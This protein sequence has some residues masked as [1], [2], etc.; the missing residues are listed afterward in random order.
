MRFTLFGGE[1]EASISKNMQ[2]HLERAEWQQAAEQ[3]SKLIKQFQPDNLGLRLKLAEIY[4]KAGLRESALAQYQE[5]AEKYVEKDNPAKAI[6]IYLT[7]L[8]IDSGLPLVRVKLAELYVKRGE[9]EEAWKQGMEAIKCLEGRRLFPQVVTTLEIMSKL[10]FAD[11]RKSM[12]LAEMLQVRNQPEKAIGQFL[13]AAELFLQN[14]D[15]EKARLAYEKVL[16]IDSAN[17]EAQKGLE[18]AALLI[19]EKEKEAA[20]AKLEMIYPQH[21]LWEDFSEDQLDEILEKLSLPKEKLPPEH[22][23]KHYELGLAYQE[24][25][26]LDAAVDEF[27]LAA[28]DPTIQ[29]ACYQMLK[30]CYEE[31]GMAGLAHEYQDKITR[32]QDNLG[33]H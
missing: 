5:T 1:T 28:Q 32:L 18:L 10:P 27:K 16:K 22:L 30:L 7:M 15:P 4:I 12:Q 24:M 14:Q 17:I 20:K 26:L 33:H 21:K 3:C 23:K 11:A 25:K 8:K 29:L 31:K 6:S 19:E 2:R 9:K 13:E